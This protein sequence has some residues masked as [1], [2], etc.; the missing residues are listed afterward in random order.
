MLFS[1]IA[2]LLSTAV[3]AAVS[4]RQTL[5]WSTVCE[6]IAASNITGEVYYPL[7][8]S[9]NFLVDTEHFM[10]S[11]SETPACVIEVG[12][13][14]DVSIVMEIV[15]STRTPFAVK[16]G[17]HASNPGFS[18]TT[19]ISISLV[20]ITQVDLSDDKSV[21]E[22]GLGNV[23]CSYICLYRLSTDANLALD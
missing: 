15:G 21:V 17:G 23:R 22:I 2:L 7:S 18:S 9:T 3:A 5:A 10:S 11:S 13:A 14:Q 16:S 19:G 6:Q 4:T 8:L 20:R 12:N 1:A